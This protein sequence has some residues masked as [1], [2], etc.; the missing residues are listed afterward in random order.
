MQRLHGQGERNQQLNRPAVSTY[1][2]NATGRSLN[3]AQYA[4]LVST[5]PGTVVKIETSGGGGA[6]FARPSTAQARR[7]KPNMPKEKVIEITEDNMYALVNEVSDLKHKS[8]YNQRLLKVPKNNNL[9]RQ[10]N[11]VSRSGAFNNE[12]VSTNYDSSMAANM[13][14]SS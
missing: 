12:H 8:F 2:T 11:Q 1:R 14:A 10:S 7:F 9:M 3:Q 4:S 5:D 6:D 13:R